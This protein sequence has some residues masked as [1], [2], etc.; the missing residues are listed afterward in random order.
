MLNGL[1]S[2]AFQ[3]VG[4]CPLKSLLEFF[5]SAGLL[6][7]SPRAYSPAGVGEETGDHGNQKAKYERKGHKIGNRR[8]VIPPVAHVQLYIFRIEIRKVKVQKQEDEKE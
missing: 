2:V 4:P 1:L 5:T 3:L 8:G 7:G 6:P